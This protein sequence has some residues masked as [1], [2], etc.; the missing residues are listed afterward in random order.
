MKKSYLIK[1]L[2]ELD[3]KDIYSL[4]L[5]VLFKLKDDSKYSTLSELVYVLNKDSLFNL[6]S[7]FGGLT[8]TIP[9][10]KD[11]QLVVSGLLIYQLVNI[12]GKDLTTS[13]KDIKTGEY[14]EAE[15]RDV[16]LKICEVVS[17]YEFKRPK[18]V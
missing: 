3:E 9:K 6:L 17:T 14:T 11:L 12:E 2:E 5:F 15:H 8:I 4:L 13:I 7:V 10:I 1:T 16:Y 18:Q